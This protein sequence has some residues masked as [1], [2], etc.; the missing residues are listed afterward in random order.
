[1]ITAADARL[2]RRD[3]EAVGALR[4]PS[5]RS[6]L[7]F[8]GML[9]L[10]LGCLLVLPVLPW[11]V[12]LLVATPLAGLFLGVAI[13]MGH[14]AAHGAACRARWQ[15]ELMLHLAFGVLAGVSAQ[16]WKWKHNGLHHSFPNVPGKDQDLHLGPIAVSAE[17]HRQSSAPVRWFQRNAQA[18]LLWPAGTLLGLVMRTRSI[19]YLVRQA[20]TKGID[21]AWLVDAGALVSHYI[22][23]LVL[24][25]LVF[26]IWAVL[27]TYVLVFGVV[28]FMLSLIFNLAHTGRPLVETYPDPWTLQIAT[29]RNVIVSRWF[30]WIWCGLD[31]QLEHHL[32]PSLSHLNLPSAAPVVRD[33]VESHGH[34]V[35]AESTWRCV[36][37]VTQHLR[38]SWQDTPIALGAPA[39][40]PREP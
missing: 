18:L 19:R 26:P 16:F 39:P 17:Q 22:L 10:G 1:M 4:A 9:G 25:A 6:W 32:M 13:L 33:W 38:E 12:A 2:L 5:A 24:P 34:T 15:N 27:G 21:R 29:V 8:L 7:K 36:G 14:E 37:L 20:A 28:G 31:R 3:L 11:P 40:E 35:D 30:R 23:W